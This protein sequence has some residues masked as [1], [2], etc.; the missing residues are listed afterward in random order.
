M[1]GQGL[2]HERLLGLPPLLS[3][4]ESQPPGLRLEL[5]QRGNQATQSGVTSLTSSTP[6]QKP[7]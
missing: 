5:A 1:R 2:S 4:V 3:L 7:S 6:F